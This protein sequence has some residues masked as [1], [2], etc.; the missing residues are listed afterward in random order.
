MALIFWLQC[1][2]LPRDE[3][4]N[5]YLKGVAN[6]TP[7]CSHVVG[8]VATEAKVKRLVLTHTRA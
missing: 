8:E 1:C 3:L 6:Y 4:T 5:E 2:W 7:A